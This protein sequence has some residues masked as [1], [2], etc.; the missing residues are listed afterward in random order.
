[1]LPGLLLNNRPAWKEFRVD[2]TVQARHMEVTDAIKQ[3]VE[4]KVGKLERFYDGLMSIDVI[5]NHE[6]DKVIAEIVATAKMKNTFVAS[7]R[8][9]DLYTAIDLA[10]HKISEQVRRHKDK[11]RDRQ[12]L[13]H[14]EIMESGKE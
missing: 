6:A 7:D 10:L 3:F 12:S 8:H 4:S 13:P 5:L 9:E 14:N 1:L 2:I 11:V